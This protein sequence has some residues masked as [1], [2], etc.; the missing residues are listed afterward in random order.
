MP[1]QTNRMHRRRYQVRGVGHYRVSGRDNSFNLVHRA[2]T[3]LWTYFLPAANHPLPGDC[4]RLP[5]CCRAHDLHAQPGGYPV[6]E[7]YDYMHGCC[8]THQLPSY[9]HPMPDGRH[10]LSGAD[11]PLPDQQPDGL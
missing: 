5:G 8:R 10:D 1:E 11:H 7:E 3:Q 9:Q 4:Y 2:W 6:P